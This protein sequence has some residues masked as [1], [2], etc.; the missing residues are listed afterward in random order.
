MSEEIVNRETAEADFD[1]FAEAWCLDTDIGSMEEEDRDSFVALKRRL[2]STIIAGKLAVAGDGEELAYTLRFPKTDGITVLTCNV[3]PGSALVALDRHK[4][5]Q[6]MTKLNTYLAAMCK[7]N[8]AVFVQM[9][10]RDLKVIQAIAT[11]F[12]AS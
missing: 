6:N 9:D 7:T 2:V 5:R 8:P 1:R 12:L 4:D 11:I 10:G 3:P